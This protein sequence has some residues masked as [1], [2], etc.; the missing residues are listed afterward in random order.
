MDDLCQYRIKGAL[1]EKNERIL[2][3]I[4]LLVEKEALSESE[5]LSLDRISLHG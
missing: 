2:E 3:K 4:G 1:I 5:I